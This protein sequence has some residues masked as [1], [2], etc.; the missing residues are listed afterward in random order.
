MN[1]RSF[2]KKALSITGVGVLAG[3]SLNSLYQPAQAKRRRRGEKS[4]GAGGMTLV[5]PGKGMAGNINYQ[6]DK[7]KIKDK[8][9]KTKRSG[10]AWKEQS[11]DNC[12]LYTDGGKKIDGKSVGK[13]TL[14]PQNYVAAKGW[15]STWNLK[16]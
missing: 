5:E 4:D 15:C 9:L 6:H 16:T 13:C 3:A 1:R 7:A 12:V 10:K 2:V 11:C 8:S 14:F